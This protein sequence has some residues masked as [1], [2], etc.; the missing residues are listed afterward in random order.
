M[1]M[2]DLKTEE[3]RAEWKKRLADNLA[4]LIADIAADKAKHGGR[5][6]TQRTR[7][8][9]GRFNNSNFGMGF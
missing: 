7:A 3:G 2:P 5:S 4:K 1:L 9:P 6:Y 8:R